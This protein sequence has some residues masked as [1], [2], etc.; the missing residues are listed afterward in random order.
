MLGVPIASSVWRTNY[1]I[2]H[3]LET[4]P[5]EIECFSWF[6]IIELTLS[7][8]NAAAFSERCLKQR[9]HVIFLTRPWIEFVAVIEHCIRSEFRN[10]FPI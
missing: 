7:T 5:A 1:A 4:S 8:V 6:F 2:E 9:D 10:L 3:N